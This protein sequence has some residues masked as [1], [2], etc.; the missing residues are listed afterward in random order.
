MER[1]DADE[2]ILYA[3]ASKGDDETMVSVEQTPRDSML[4][5]IRNLGL[6]ESVVIDFRAANV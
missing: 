6:D 4:F 1:V 2:A 5:V 3:T